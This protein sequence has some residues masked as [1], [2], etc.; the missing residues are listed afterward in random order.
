[1][2]HDDDMK[3]PTFG[4]L[5]DLW[6]RLEERHQGYWD[7][8]RR[9]E[10]MKDQPPIVGPE[11]PPTR[12]PPTMKC[13][14][15][16]G[17]DAGLWKFFSEYFFSSLME[18]LQSFQSSME[19]GMF[20]VKSPSWVEPPITTIRLDRKTNFNTPVVLPP[21]GPAG[22]F[23]TVLIIDV[24]DLTV[25]TLWGISNSVCL[26][27]GLDTVEFREVRNGAPITDGQYVGGKLNFD[28]INRDSE[29]VP[30]FLPPLSRFEIQARNIA[31]VG[32]QEALCRVTGQLLPIRDIAPDRFTQFHVY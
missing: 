13:P 4:S 11:C 15:P 9:S 28:H 8:Y 7:I 10:A 21:V 31:L 16:P 17:F 24:P 1:M 6:S 26:G 18:T 29:P 22:A 25:A 2:P 3:V 27:T 20:F 19:R 30:V 5:G 12:I 23:T 14:P 32:D